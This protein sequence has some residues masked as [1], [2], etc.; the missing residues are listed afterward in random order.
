MKLSKKELL[1]YR[2]LRRRNKFNKTEQRFVTINDVI[3]Y[4]TFV[5]G[6]INNEEG[7]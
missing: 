5:L 1:N 7:D 2:T 6:K 4:K 3:R